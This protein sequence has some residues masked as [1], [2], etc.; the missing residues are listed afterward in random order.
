MKLSSS[1]VLLVGAD[2]FDI[3]QYLLL[4]NQMN[5]SQ[6]SKGYDMKRYLLSKTNNDI[7]VNSNLAS[8]LSDATKSNYLTQI[9]AVSNNPLSMMDLFMGGQS[10][11][12]INTE[13]WLE[14]QKEQMMNQMFANMNDSPQSQMMFQYMAGGKGFVDRDQMIYSS[15]GEPMGTIMRL[16]KNN[17]AV[18]D[19]LMKRYIAQQSFGNDPILPDLFVN[20]DKEG[21]KQY[22][23][24]KQFETMETQPGGEFMKTLMYRKLTGQKDSAVTDKELLAAGTFAA[25]LDQNGA[26][27]KPNDAYLMFKFLKS[28]TDK[29]NGVPPQTILEVALGQDVAAIKTEDFEQLFGIEQTEFVC[30]AHENS[31]RVPCLVNQA[32]VTADECPKHCCFNTLTSSGDQQASDRVPVCYHNLLGKIGAGIAKHLIND[33]N[34]EQLFGGQMPSLTDLTDAQEWGESQMPEVLRRLNKDE[35]DF[36]GN[37]KNQ[38]GWWQNTYDSDSG[39][40]NIYITPAPAVATNAKWKPAGPTALPYTSFVPETG[41]YGVGREQ[42]SDPLIAMDQIVN[43]EIAKVKAQLNSDSY[44]CKLIPKEHMVNCYNNNYDALA[45]P[46]AESSCNKKGCCYREQ[47]LFEDKPVCFRSL[48]AGFCD[49]NG[50][51]LDATNQKAHDWWSANPKRVACGSQA[52]VTKNEC[53]LNP[54]C[55]YSENARIGGDPV[56]YHRGGV[57]SIAAATG[58]LGDDAQCAAVNVAL[59]EPC[60]DNS[61]KFGQIFNKVAKQDQCQMAGCCYDATAAKAA[62]QVSGLLGGSIDFTGPHCFKKPQPDNDGQWAE[63]DRVQI[64]KPSQLVKTCDDTRT[65]TSGD[66]L[67]PQVLQNKWEK[68]SGQWKYVETNEKTPAEREQ[69]SATTDMHECVY[70]L[71]CCFEKS[72][73]PREAWCYKPRYVQS[74]NGLTGALPGTP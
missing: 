74:Q 16:K 51:S 39:N 9:N 38:P 64:Y 47:N 50:E 65:T 73:D 30:V 15:M 72:V 3:K 26:S 67:W 12:G 62:E 57:E 43:A 46:N 24:S 33:N 19:R 68:I 5:M 20:N 70:T 36:F 6:P 69:C 59:R 2:A 53:L 37:P 63:V 48:R 45:A 23:I 17:V 71:G 41:K 54:Q 56:C 49:P 40:F 44:T 14:T 1:F 18:G 21:I 29:N 55:C 28:Q 35:G 52:G 7:M 11:T 22:M 31:I 66:P 27:V 58:S 13:S 25:K 10:M 34:I 8:P 61:K 4:Q 42:D 60:F 32:T